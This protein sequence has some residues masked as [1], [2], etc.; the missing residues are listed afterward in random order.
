MA[1]TVTSYKNLV[2]GEWVDAARGETM[3]V[4]NP[5]TG[6]AIAEVPRGSEQDV[7]R[8]GELQQHLGALTGRRLQPLG[9]RL[10]RGLD[11]AVDVLCRCARHLGDRVAGRRV[12]HLHGLAAGGVDP[13]A[14][15]EVLVT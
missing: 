14:A 1:T 2:G 9:Q 7:E 12:E 11:G 15:D 6:E 8:V 3:E 13:L 10:L 5:A 4:L